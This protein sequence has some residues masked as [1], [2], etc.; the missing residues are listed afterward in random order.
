MIQKNN[1]DNYW[2]AR[3]TQFAAVYEIM[4]D[5]IDSILFSWFSCA[6]KAADDNDDREKEEE[7]SE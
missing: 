2:L 5:S 6:A 1:S 3:F 4:A 7:Y